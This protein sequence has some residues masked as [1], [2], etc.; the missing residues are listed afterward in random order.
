MDKLCVQTAAVRLVLQGLWQAKLLRWRGWRQ[1]HHQLPDSDARV[2]AERASRGG[3]A[4]DGGARLRRDAPTRARVFW[5]ACGRVARVERGWGGVVVARSHAQQKDGVAAA[6]GGVGALRGPG[7]GRRAVAGR[8]A[9][10][11]HRSDGRPPQREHE[12]ARRRLRA[13][14]RGAG[15]GAKQADDGAARHEPRRRARVHGGAVSLPESHETTQH[16]SRRLLLQPPQL[17]LGNQLSAVVSLFASFDSRRRH[18]P[19]SFPS[20]L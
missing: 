9:Q 6:G 7:E 13:G 12:H 11:P 5:V 4:D 16:S 3:G 8:E 18:D 2:A 17:N 19:I 15:A 10:L 14:G 1:A 20:R